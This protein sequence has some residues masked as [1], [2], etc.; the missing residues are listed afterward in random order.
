MKK[1]IDIRTEEEL[2]RDVEGRVKSARE[3]YER[4]V[5]KMLQETPTSYD[6]HQIAYA[7][8]TYKT[9]KRC[10]KSDERPWSTK[11]LLIATRDEL[12][13]NIMTNQYRPN[14][15]SMAENFLDQIKLQVACD[16]VDQWY[17]LELE[18]QDE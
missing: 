3:Q 8:H 1:R 15:S 2:T 11:E 14:S 7:L 13:S 9:Y 4:L 6:F 16:F 18:K 12:R 10:T 5:G 17:N